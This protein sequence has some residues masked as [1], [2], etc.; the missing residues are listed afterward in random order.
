MQV[1]LVV[2]PAL[3]L[4]YFLPFFILLSKKESLKSILNGFFIAGLTLDLYSN[5]VPF[6][7]Y[8]LLCSLLAL[9]VPL[10]SK[11]NLNNE[12]LT[13]LNNTVLFIW[14]WNLT[15]IPLSFFFKLPLTLSF[16][17]IISEFFFY[18][19]ANIAYT[20]FLVFIP[21]ALIFKKPQESIN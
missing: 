20:C 5:S 7:Y 2:T 3:K 16:K 17:W 11:K 21:A 14:L 19:L 18:L 1:L 6:G 12:W 9:F 4:L 15:Q 10:W 13:L 8:T